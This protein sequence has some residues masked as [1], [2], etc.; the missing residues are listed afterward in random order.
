[1]RRVRSQS[2]AEGTYHGEAFN[3]IGLHVHFTV[4]GK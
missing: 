2:E 3:K 1:M 4:G